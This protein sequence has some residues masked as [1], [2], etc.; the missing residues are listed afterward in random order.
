MPDD[1]DGPHQ[2]EA[3]SDQPAAYPP[4][5]PAYPPPG[6]P[7]P[8]PGYPPPPARRPGSPPP[9]PGSPPPG[10]PP[11]SYPPPPPY[12]PHPGMPS[13]PGSSSPAGP[14]TV[15]DPGL[16]GAAP[17]SGRCAATGSHGGDL[18]LGGPRRRH[19]GRRGGDADRHV[20]SEPDGHL[21]RR[22]TPGASG[23]DGDDRRGLVPLRVALHLPGRD[24]DHRRRRRAASGHDRSSPSAPTPSR[25]S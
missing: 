9:P 24:P 1:A 21:A 15:P 11:P 10:Y 16:R 2:E 19:P 18:R 14:G 8:P 17:G 20:R 25:S 13:G 5:P 7:P 22:P 6:Y 4:P 12:P 23:V 3:P